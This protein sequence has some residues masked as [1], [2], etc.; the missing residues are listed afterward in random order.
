LAVVGVDID[1][2]GRSAS[3][4]A[5]T[6]DP[7]IPDGVLLEVIE[8]GPGSIW[9]ADAVR[10]IAST[11]QLVAIDDYGPGHD[12]ILALRDHAALDGRLLPLKSVEFSS[13]C[14]VIDARIREHRLRHRPHPALTAAAASAERTTGK[15]W[16]WERRVGI[17]QAPLV[18]GTLATWA[19]EHA[20]AVTPDPAIY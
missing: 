12:L 15:S 5:A 13:A 11:V 6:P 18:A 14:Y 9:V 10:A 1:P 3:I 7:A 4:V 19:L 17:S 2:F 20:P 16:Q 8:H